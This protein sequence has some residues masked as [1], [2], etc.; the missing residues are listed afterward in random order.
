MSEEIN[1][2]EN[3][4]YSLFLQSKEIN[5]KI[6]QIKKLIAKL[7]NKIEIKENKKITLTSDLE[8]KVLKSRLQKKF[9]EEEILKSQHQQIYNL[10]KQQINENIEHI[11]NRNFKEF[12]NKYEF[13]PEQNLKITLKNLY[14]HFQQYDQ[15][16]TPYKKFKCL[17]DDLKLFTT[18]KTRTD[19]TIFY[20][21]KLK[22]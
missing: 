21:I 8:I 7:E 13:E 17:M 20:G 5:E 1:K 12:I 11:N 3:D 22:I 18:N 2:L 9:K 10:Y 15:I 19:R 16:K 4:N 14:N 6:K